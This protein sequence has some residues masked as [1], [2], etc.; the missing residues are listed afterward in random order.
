MTK[1]ASVQLQKS[2]IVDYSHLNEHDPDFNSDSDD[3]SCEGMD[4]TENYADNEDSIDGSEDED[5]LSGHLCNVSST[6]F[7][8]MR[9]FDSIKQTLA[10]WYFIVNING[11]KKYLH[12]QT[13]A[14][15]LSNDK[16]TLSSDRLKRVMTNN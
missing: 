8:G 3:S 2:K 15:L 6:S 9:F 10:K 11:T 5:Y 12:K 4:T 1:L 7:Q 13:A 16:S 14:W